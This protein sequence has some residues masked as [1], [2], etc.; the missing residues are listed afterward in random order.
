MATVTGDGPRL[1]LGERDRRYSE[2]RARLTE[3]GVDCVVVVGSNLLYLSN[4]LPG[5]QVGVFPTRDEPFMVALNRRHLVDVPAQVLVDAQ[6]WV[7]D[8]RAGG[9]AATVADRVRELRLE[10][11]TI[12]VADSRAAIGGL[13]HGM[14]AQLQQ[15]LP[16]A[17]LEDVTDIFLDLRTIKSEEEIALIER[18]NVLFDL[19]VERIHRVARPGMR[20]IEVVQ[21]GIKAM[22]EAGGDLDSSL[23]FTFG[24]VPKQNPILGALGR[25]RQIQPGDIGTLTA[26]AEYH[27]YG[28]HSDQEISFGEPKPAHRAMFDAVLHVRDEVL[29]HV[30]PG[31]THGELASVYEGACRQTGFRSSPHS[32]MHQYG[33]DVPEFPGPSFLIASRGAPRGGRGDFTLQPGMVYSISPTLVAP[34]AD[35]TL[36]GGTSLVVTQDGYRELG[37][38]KVELLVAAG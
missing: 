7:K 26:H 11:G 1:T 23:G 12:G 5:E 38:R 30:R 34:D 18:A 31:V 9:D 36:L 33:I 21:E 13:S 22:W 28:G 27:R 8:I 4:G 17:K 24:A 20:G 25:D 6:D 35:D 14:Y 19:A 15:A 16:N 29:R 32:Q 3:R 2:L 37:D 10:R